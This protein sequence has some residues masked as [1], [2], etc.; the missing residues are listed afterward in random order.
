MIFVWMELERQFPVGFLELFIA[1]IF[2][3]SQHLI[4]VLTPFYS[5]GQEQTSDVI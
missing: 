4:V 1:V 2:T 5:G 3:D